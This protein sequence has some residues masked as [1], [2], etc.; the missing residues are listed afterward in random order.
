MPRIM[1][2][3]YG[4]K[5]CGI[6]VTDPLKIIAAA[7]TTV[8]TKSLLP[9]LKNYFLQESV[10]L[11][12]IGEPQNLDDSYTHA[13]PLVHQFINKFKNEFPQMPVATIDE[14][15]SSKLAVQSMLEMGM[16]KKERR[17]KANIDQ[18]AATMLLQ[19]YLHQLKL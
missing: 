1:C 10:E 5:R 11:L 4:A 13:T 2:I 19:E 17:K 3:D 14:R 6:A 7:L 16:K 8:E 15:Y 9:F 18:V 12:L